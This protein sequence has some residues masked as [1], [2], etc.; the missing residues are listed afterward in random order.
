MPDAP[1]PASIQGAFQSSLA[2][3]LP[4]DVR[5]KVTIDTP[6]QVLT[7][8]GQPSHWHVA[9]RLDGRT[10]GFMDFGLN[11]ELE[12]YGSRI[13]N[14]GDVQGL[15]PDV[16]DM[17]PADRAAKAR[18]ALK[19]GGTLE[20]TAKLV[21]DQSPTRLSWMYQGREADGTAL[22]VYVTPQFSWSEPAQAKPA[23]GRDSVEG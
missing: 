16:M 18:D 13:Q 14:P 7:P 17:H 15:A 10:V 11:G 1:S 23:G 9:V 5:G 4:Q 8:D 2:G 21:A 6:A 22:R 19:P 20:N 12:R 3:E